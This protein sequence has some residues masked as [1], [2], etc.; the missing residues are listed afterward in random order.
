VNNDG[1]ASGLLAKPSDEAQAELLRT[2]YR[3]AGVAPGAVPYV[4]AHGTGTEAGDPTE[5]KGLGSVLGAA[6]PRQRPLMVGSIKTNIGHTEACAGL[7]GLIKTTLVLEHGVIPANLHLQEPSSKIDWREL[8]VSVPQMAVPWPA[9]ELRLAGVS[10]FGITGT[11]AHAILAAAGR[12]PRVSRAP[13]SP[14]VVTVS[15]ATPAALR[16]AVEWLLAWLQ[17]RPDTDLADLS[18]TTTCR[19]DHHAH[20]LA[21]VAES[22]EEVTAAL[23]RHLAG[24]AMPDV[25]VG[26][27]GSGSAPA[28]VFSGQG[29]QWV[30]MGRA[31]MGWAPAFTTSIDQ[32]DAIVRTLGGWSIRDVLASDSTEALERV[33]IVQPTLACV[34]IALAA[35]LRA[36]G[37][38]PGA[39][40]GHSM[41]EVAA[42]HV[43]G[44]LSLEDALRVI[45]AR[46]QLLREI[47]GA[48]A[49]AL[50]DLDAA[51]AAERIAATG[52]SISI[53]AIN[54]PRSTVISGDPERIDALLEQL[55]DEDIFCRRVKVDVASH[56]AQTDPL[57]PRLAAEL[58]VIAPRRPAVP[59]HSTARPD[60]PTDL[61]L[62]AA[63]WVDNLRRPVQLHSAVNAMIGADID[64][65]VE[66]AP[67]PV[68]LTALADIAAGSDRSVRTTA[69]L[70]RDEPER[71]RLLELLARLHVAGVPVNWAKV[72]G[73]AR[74]PLR[75]PAYPWQRE[76]FW[77]EQWEDW[78]G[79]PSA[80]GR[81]AVLPAE[82]GSWLYRLDWI[83][84]PSSSP[85][86]ADGGEWL[87]LS[88]PTPLAAAVR[89]SLAERG[90]LAAVVPPDPDRLEALL[91]G[92][93]EVR[94]L[95]LL[96]ADAQPRG[97]AS[98]ATATLLRV[99]RALLRDGAGPQPQLLVVTRGSQ[100][101]PGGAPTAAGV[102]AAPLWGFARVLRDEQP[103]LA[104]RLLDLDPAA[105]TDAAAVAVADAALD[106][107]DD[108]ATAV[109]GGRRF[110]PRLE[111]QSA[112]EMPANGA[113]PTQGATLIT[114][115]LGDLGLAV[116]RELVDRGVRRLVL[117]SRTGVPPR[118]DW[119]SADPA[120]TAGRRIAAVRELEALGA[121]V[122]CPAFDVSNAQS[123]AAFLTRY[124]D[125]AWPE[126]VAVVHVAGG[127]DSHLVRS[128]SEASLD[129][130]FRAK[131]DGA[132]ALHAA[133]PQVQ[134]FV[135]FSS[136]SVLIPQAG[137]ANYAAANGFLDALAAFR[138][139]A[140]QAAQVI[141]W[142]VWRGS[143]VIAN[144]EGARYVDEVRRQGIDAMDPT[145]A[146]RVFSVVAAAGLGQVMVAPIDW[147][148]LKQTR[149]A[150]HLGPTFERILAGDAAGGAVTGAARAQLE[151]MPRSEWR[152]AID[153][154]L[155]EIIAKVLGLQPATVRANATLGSQGLDSLMALEL[156]NHLEGAFDLKV[157]AT[158]AWNYPTLEKLTTHLAAELLRRTDGAGTD[159]ERR[160]PGG[161]G[162]ATGRAGIT[163]PD[164][165]P[166]GDAATRPAGETGSAAVESQPASE[167]E[168]SLTARVQQLAGS[169][170]DDILRE[171]R[172]DA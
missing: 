162:S 84:S 161:N 71:R 24:E 145:A 170:E 124:E 1:Q 75:L 61:R 113:W 59:F 125:E 43:A 45:V 27:R 107:T 21:V 28:F 10:S 111:R 121:S 150:A 94:G 42:A 164:G 108:A 141:N 103:E 81:A 5:L 93:H 138:Q 22:I 34:Q 151:R 132:W 69:G 48:G 100:A 11:N 8:N 92:D 143:G 171:L 83:E 90:L 154:T 68:L 139:A 46:S 23:T 172:G 25:A 140:G 58:A 66:V 19:R 163:A 130:V 126:I 6:R 158:L 131:A 76:R 9:D 44:A 62:D 41:G 88:P 52:N 95:V 73:G 47:A 122:Q 77:P 149:G 87:V 165:G 153:G 109:R 91:R 166:D 31:L 16:A 128:M 123:L 101:V 134:R 89:E 18:Y 78:S 38:E 14:A 74:K 148:R 159:G 7:A 26:E 98:A 30:G 133:F 63:Y 168:W 15:G 120:S 97:S 29:S 105:P 152:G 82:S 3:S 49:M 99:A 72:V 127:I 136:T 135:L 112:P 114:G 116:A 35:Q 137:E 167:P 13:L 20:R 60:A 102:F 85:A 144:A 169:S 53:A 119:R 40:V 51:E 39:V 70:R 155:R 104:V 80:A 118:T 157:S 2:V 4:E 129:R 36:W 56:S 142:G 33:D 79:E 106:A 110:V 156:R 32:C 147:E 65:F 50:V 54:G 160:V 57:L 117:T 12:Q 115:G 17:E 37:V 55:E 96:A 64:T 146:A 67:H 86:R